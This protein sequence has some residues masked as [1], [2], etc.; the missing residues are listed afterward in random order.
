M[1][2]YIADV[3]WYGVLLIVLALAMIFMVGRVNELFLLWLRGRS[4]IV[5]RMTTAAM[6]VASV[7]IM[8]F[9]ATQLAS[10]N[11]CVG[12]SIEKAACNGAERAR[13]RKSYPRVAMMQRRQNE[14][15]DNVPRVVRRVHGEF[16]SFSH[17]RRGAGSLVS[18]QLRATVHI[19][20]SFAHIRRP[21]AG[22]YCQTP[23]PGRSTR[24]RGRIALRE[25][26]VFA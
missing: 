22:H 16:V 19:D 25:H 10:L 11:S 23:A 26:P 17:K 4:P 1:R 21:L 13:S 8:I 18:C 15:S 20:D 6:I 14:R 7:L 3:D 12:S 24:R 2:Q 5:L 9:L